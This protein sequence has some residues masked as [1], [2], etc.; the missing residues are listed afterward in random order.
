MQG[1]GSFERFVKHNNGTYTLLSK[2]EITPKQVNRF[3]ISTE[4]FNWKLTDDVD[5]N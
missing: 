5:I 2:V 4:F 1:R 3:Y